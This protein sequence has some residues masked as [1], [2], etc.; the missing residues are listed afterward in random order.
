LLKRAPEKQSEECATKW[1]IKDLGQENPGMKGN[2]REGYPSTS[3]GLGWR[4]SE[5]CHHERYVG[6]HLLFINFECGF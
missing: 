6:L 1:D 4:A 5:A 2:I 3:T